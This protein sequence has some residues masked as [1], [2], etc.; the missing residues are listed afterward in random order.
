MACGIIQWTMDGDEVGF[1]Q[2]GIEVFQL[3]SLR[4]LFKIGVE[5]DHPDT[6]A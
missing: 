4:S 5:G 1:L 3:N 6:K 2:N